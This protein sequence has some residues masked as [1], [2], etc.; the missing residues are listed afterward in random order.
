M[1][2]NYAIVSHK[3]RIV[4]KKYIKKIYNLIAGKYKCMCRPPL[5]F[6]KDLPGCCELL[7]FST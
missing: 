6:T 7:I 3:W 1:M 2:K 5:A 4:G